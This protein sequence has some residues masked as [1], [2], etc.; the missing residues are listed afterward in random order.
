MYSL[1]QV[2]LKYVQESNYRGLVSK[3]SKS[4][5]LHKQLLEITSQFTNFSCSQRLY[6]V[7]N[8]MDDMPVCT[9]GNLVKY[10]NITIGYF[11]YCSKKCAV[12]SEY[13][14]NKIKKTN[15]KKYGCDWFVQTD[16][17]K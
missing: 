3:V 14:Q 4:N 2:I 11:E 1:E 12:T 10:K 5:G 8:D 7:I 17:C 16:L 15:N 9:C 6:H 13:T